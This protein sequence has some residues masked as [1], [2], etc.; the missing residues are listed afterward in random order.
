MIHSPPARF[1]DWNR[2]NIHRRLY[3]QG[4]VC[5]GN[6]NLNNCLYWSPSS[7]L[8]SPSWNRVQQMT[9]N[10]FSYTEEQHRANLAAVGAPQTFCGCSPDLLQSLFPT[11]LS[12]WCSQTFCN[13]C[14]PHS[15]PL[16]APQQFPNHCFP[17]NHPSGA[18]RPSAIIDFH[19]VIFLV[20]PDL[21]QSLLPT[22]SMPTKNYLQDP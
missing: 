10:P 16:D 20:L 5:Q 22:Q 4:R 6:K 18:P 14:F 11:L 9:C 3:R 17:H 12:S 8:G 13:H 21:L 15:H 19:A 2:L 7:N 1:S